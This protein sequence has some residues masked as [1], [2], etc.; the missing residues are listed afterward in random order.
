M[1]TSWKE[2]GRPPKV[3]RVT[4]FFRRHCIIKINHKPYCLTQLVSNWTGKT[5]GNVSDCFFSLMPTFSS[6][7]LSTTYLNVLTFVAVPFVL[8]ICY[9]DSEAKCKYCRSFVLFVKLA[10]HRMFW[11]RFCK[12]I[13]KM[14]LSRSLKAMNM[15]SSFK[16]FM[17]SFVVL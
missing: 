6:C 4:I 3:C 16:I 10:F 9:S 11:K 5:I 12:V 8:C 7:F 2:Q 17:I 1:N 15:S 14:S 13:C